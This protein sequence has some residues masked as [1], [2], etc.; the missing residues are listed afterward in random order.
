MILNQI[1]CDDVLFVWYIYLSFLQPTSV[2]IGVHNNEI[3][4]TNSFILGMSFHWFL[5]PYLF[6]VFASL[7]I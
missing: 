4:L 1:Q 2:M 5:D 7:S 6:S 3:Y